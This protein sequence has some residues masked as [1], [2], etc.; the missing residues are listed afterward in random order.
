MKRH[1]II[2]HKCEVS[3][4]LLHQ[5]LFLSPAFS[6]RTSLEAA[7]ETKESTSYMCSSK[8][9]EV[10]GC[11]NHFND[12]FLLPQS[13][14]Q[15]SQLNYSS[16]TNNWTISH[17]PNQ[18]TTICY[19]LRRSIWNSLLEFSLHEVYRKATWR[20]KG[21]NGKWGRRLARLREEEEKETQ[22]K[23][24]CPGARKCW[25]VHWSRVRPESIFWTYFW[26]I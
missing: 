11:K 25:P 21:S 18:V 4:K 5:P 9:I 3:S 26:G 1:S 23:C 12:G 16:M 10:H 8:G 15:T 17:V 20:T 19:L 6:S 22:C 2:L 13:T 24:W 14:T 7:I